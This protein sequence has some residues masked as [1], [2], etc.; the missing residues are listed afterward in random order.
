MY[1]GYF[2]EETLEKVLQERVDSYDQELKKWNLDEYLLGVIAD[3]IQEF[4]N[5]A[6]SYPA[7]EPYNSYEK[8]INFLNAL[9][10]KFR[11]LKGKVYSIIDKDEAKRLKK[12]RK[13][14]FSELAEWL[15]SMWN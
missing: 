15:P 4:A 9:A 10:G 5:S 7:I 13:Q 14:A 8:W 2:M 3:S 1:K 6:T 11:Y 12:L